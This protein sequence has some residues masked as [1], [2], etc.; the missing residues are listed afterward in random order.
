M[1]TTEEKYDL[2]R[3]KECVVVWFKNSLLDVAEK[4]EVLLEGLFEPAKSIDRRME[5][6]RALSTTAMDGDSLEARCNSIAVSLMSVSRRLVGIAQLGNLN[7][8]YSELNDAL[9]KISDLDKVI[10]T[11]GGYL[12]DTKDVVQWLMTQLPNGGDGTIGGIKERMNTL[13]FDILSFL[14]QTNTDGLA[15]HG[16]RCL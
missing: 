13:H 1:G 2:S 5:S 8:L 4:C 7:A 12:A 11:K 16:N 10:K 15:E 3:D 9:N 6:E 14:I